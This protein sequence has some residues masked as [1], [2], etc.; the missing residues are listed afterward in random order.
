MN[1][2]KLTEKDTLIIKLLGETGSM[3]L[4]ELS[5]RMLTPPSQTLKIIENLQRSRYIEI[6]P[7]EEGIENKAYFLNSNGRKL[8]AVLS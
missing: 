4:S 5:A 3:T 6:A 1:L 8:W 2:E 7:V